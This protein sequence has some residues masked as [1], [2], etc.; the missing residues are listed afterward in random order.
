MGDYSLDEFVADL[1][2]VAANNDDVHDILKRLPPQPLRPWA[3][4]T[5]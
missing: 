1:R 2:A 4:R 5:G 3:R